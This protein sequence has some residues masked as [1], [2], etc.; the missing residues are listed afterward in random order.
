MRALTAGCECFRSAFA[1]FV[2]CLLIVVGV[3]PAQ[4]I[5]FRFL[6]QPMQIELTAPHVE[7]IP[8]PTSAR[9]EQARLL[10]AAHSWNEAVDIY[11]ELIAD[12]SG[13]VVAVDGNR[14][15]GLPNYCHL[16]IARLPSEGLAT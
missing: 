2:I 15:F 14:Y 1:A 9:L 6:N 3:T 11:L 13:G 4:Q 16:Q 8:G 12:K 5:P 7:V 10:A